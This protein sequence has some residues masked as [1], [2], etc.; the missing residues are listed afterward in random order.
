[1]K[2]AIVLGQTSAAML[3]TLFC[4]AV[5]AGE[6]MRAFDNP[7]YGQGMGNPMKGTKAPYKTTMHGSSDRA[8]SFDYKVPFDLPKR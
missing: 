4:P 2:L 3:A 8:A 6:G 1:V 7:P 5:E